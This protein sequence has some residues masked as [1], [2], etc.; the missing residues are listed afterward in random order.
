MNRTIACAALALTAALA[1][2]ARA[3]SSLTDP[4]KAKATA[5]AVYKVKLATTKGDVVIEVHRDWAP[6][7]ADRFYNLVKLG[8]FNDV[9]FFR[10]IKGF[11]VQFGIH[12]DPAVNRAWHNANIQDDPS[13][14]QSNTRGMVTF[15]TAGPNT[16]TTQLFINY[17]DN[18]RLDSMGFA[19]IGKV[20]SGMDVVDKLEGVYGEGA[21]MG[22]GPAQGKLQ[23]EGNA[24]LK[25]QFPKLDY[26]K[27]ATVAP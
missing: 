15:A 27:S 19:P 2:I 18:A 12:G 24:Y 23:N 9:A 8:Y 22:A 13:G 11:M 20:V 4:T 17:G 21:P 3:D 7:G 16:R 5:P 14:K 25:A 6:V 1:P 10:V 26:L